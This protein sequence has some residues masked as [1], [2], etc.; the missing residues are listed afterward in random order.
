[1][2]EQIK[3]WMEDETMVSVVLKHGNGAEGIISSYDNVGIVLTEDTGVEKVI[4][5][6]SIESINQSLCWDN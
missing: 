5:Y 6:T 4:P 1:M 2:V 3:K